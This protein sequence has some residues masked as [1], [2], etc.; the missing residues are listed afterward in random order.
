[1]KKIAIC[2][3][4]ILNVVSIDE[5]Q[6]VECMIYVASENHCSMAFLREQ[7]KI[8]KGKKK[9]KN[10][11]HPL[12]KNCVTEKK[13]ICVLLTKMKLDEKDTFIYS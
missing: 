7:I 12:S 2:F 3:K 1:V 13:V 6:I 9:K 11:T 5:F 10:R 8:L 4:K